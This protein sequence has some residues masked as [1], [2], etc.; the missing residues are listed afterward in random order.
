MSQ[1]LLLLLI[2]L[3][4]VRLQRTKYTRTKQTTN[5]RNHVRA[6]RISSMQTVMI[7]EPN[8]SPEIKGVT[9]RANLKS[10]PLLSARPRTEGSRADRVALE[11]ACRQLVS[12]DFVGIVQ[13]LIGLPVANPRWPRTRMFLYNP[14]KRKKA[15][16]IPTHRRVSAELSGCVSGTGNKQGLSTSKVTFKVAREKGVFV[17]RGSKGQPG[18][19]GAF[20]RLER[21]SCCDE[22]LVR[23][24]WKCHECWSAVLSH[25]KQTLKL[26]KPWHIAEDAET[27]ENQS[28]P[29]VLLNQNGNA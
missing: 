20:R 16:A 15:T 1:K 9:M 25:S 22:M 27:A 11:R 6:G 10:L 2:F 13:E 4:E 28:K 23:Q 26:R 5:Y 19:W 14:D 7:D 29:H 24:T 12:V 21:K 3:L 18:E 17:A 8:E